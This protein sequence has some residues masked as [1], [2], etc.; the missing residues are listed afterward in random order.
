MDA[1]FESDTRYVIVNKS[2]KG[3][4]IRLNKP[5]SQ[6][7]QFSWIA[8]SVKKAHAFSSD[9]EPVSYEEEKV[10]KKEETGRRGHT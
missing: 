10:S 3:F 8:L 4:T 7:L 1:Y 9:E 2:Q 5:A 6:E